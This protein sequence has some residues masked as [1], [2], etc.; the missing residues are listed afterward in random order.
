MEDMLD[1]VKTTRYQ[2]GTFS[3]MS[4]E[5]DTFLDKVRDFTNR[6]EGFFSERGNIALVAYAVIALLVL[7]NYLRGWFAARIRWR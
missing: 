6:L 5:I 2:I 1:S 4:D 7:V 3:H